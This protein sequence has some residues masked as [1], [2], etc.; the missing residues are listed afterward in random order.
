MAN[1]KFKVKNGLIAPTI[2]STVATGTAPFIVA[3]TTP[4]DNLCIG[5]NAATA[6]SATSST[7]ST[8]LIGGDN[9]TLL[10]SIPYQSNVDTTTLLGPNVSATKKWLN[11]TG[12]GTNGAAPVW[13]A[14][15]DADIANSIVIGK[16]ITGFTSGSGT[17]AA[18]DTILQAIQKLDG[19]QNASLSL[20]GNLKTNS[21]AV[22]FQSIVTNNTTTTFTITSP[23]YT[24][25]TGSSNQIVVLP[26][27]T[28]LKLGW[29]Y[30]I[31]NDSTGAITINTNGGATIWIIGA[32]ADICLT[33][34]SISTA[35]G[36]WQK[37][38]IA[39]K[40]AT[41]KVLTVNNTI[42]LTGTDT[43]TMTFPS[44][45]ATVLST[46]AAVT[47]AQGGTGLATLTDKSVLVGAGTGNV[48]FV[49]P[50]ANNNV[51]TSNGTSWTSAAPSGGGATIT[52]DS[53]T[54]SNQ[55]VIMSRATSGTFSAAYTDSAALY[56]NP[57]TALL[58]A[59]GFNSLS[60]ENEKNNIEVIKNALSM[61]SNLRG[62]TFD[63]KRN[64]L[65]S[66]G[67]IAQDVEQVLP[68]IVSISNNKKSLNYN[69]VIAILVE[70][71]KQL[72]N[73][74]NL[75][76]QELHNK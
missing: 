55:N 15:V 48:A 42:T 8:N 27:A 46:A 22:G 41:G 61:I 53:S 1:D 63:W 67:L 40:T 64:G 43:T 35:A 28:T 13:T 51:L 7:K 57:S 30:E 3:S 75:L 33:C 14:I 59:I 39:T 49:A 23:Y 37:D 24:I 10:G 56:F 62:V 9:A 45:S 29:K 73:K 47:V 34:S 66:A 16:L 19:N 6:T 38:Y 70:G 36:T 76:E 60:D 58:S 25:F 68:E 5:G 72:N 2:E 44:I 54:N 11:Q 69:G 26:D 32:S 50:G 31:D 52:E 74:V 12:N 71:M 18:T 65:A 17:V 21:L 20:T 4:V